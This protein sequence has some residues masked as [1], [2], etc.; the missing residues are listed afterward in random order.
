MLE[1]DRLLLRRL[2]L[3]DFEFI[4]RLVNEASFI[5]NIGD[6][7]VR[8]DDDARS[9]IQNGPLASYERFGFG[10]YLIE[11]KDSSTPIGICGLLKRDSFEFP[12]LGY[13][14]LPDYWSR[15]YALEA[16]SSVLNYARN[17]LNLHRLLAIVNADNF[18]SIRLLEKCGFR[19]E[20][21]VR[22][23]DEAEV[24]LY[25]CD[26]PAHTPDYLTT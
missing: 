12:D 22:L 4:R 13:A 1:T 10:L 18:A 25:S 8:N 6:R 20:N 2:S 16:A 7:G 9:Y 15:G 23:A 21:T 24:Q 26:L 17:E 19:F 3:D 14:L 11:L 5:K